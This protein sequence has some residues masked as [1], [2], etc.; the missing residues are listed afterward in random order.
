[1]SEKAPFIR[2]AIIGLGALRFSRFSHDATESR[3]VAHSSAITADYSYALS[4]YGRALR[5]VNAAISRGERDINKILLACI[6]LFCFQTMSGNAASAVANATSGMMLLLQWI[7]THPNQ[8][9]EF[10]LNNEWQEQPIDEDLMLALAGLDMQVLFFLDNRPEPVHLFMVEE[11]NKIIPLMPDSFLSLK[12]ARRSWSLIMRR[13]FHFIKVAMIRAGVYEVARQWKYGAE[14]P[15]EDCLDVLP[16][17]NLFCAPRDP[18]MEMLPQSQGYQE[19]CRPEY[20]FLY[21]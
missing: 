17:G 13:N 14:A 15:W 7:Q 10:F 19:V 9:A 4:Q 20:L 11:A 2:H 18:R 6:L 12:A 3:Q 5:G 8:S 1:M 16:G 21:H